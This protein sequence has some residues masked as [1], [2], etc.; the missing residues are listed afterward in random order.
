MIKTEYGRVFYALMKKGKRKLTEHFLCVPHCTHNWRLFT[1]ICE[2]SNYCQLCTFETIALQA[3]RTPCLVTVKLP[4][5]IWCC[6]LK[7]ESRIKYYTKENAFRQKFCEFCLFFFFLSLLPPI[8]FWYLSSCFRKI[9]VRS[10]M[11]ESN[12]FIS[13]WP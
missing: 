4:D 13:D 12:A 10:E 2:A 7:K 8:S 1:R 9:Q 3:A 6:G 11:C 5:I